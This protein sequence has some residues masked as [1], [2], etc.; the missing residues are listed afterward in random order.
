MAAVGFVKI[1][2]DIKNHWIYRD[3]DHFK[4]WFEMLSNA[5]YIEEPKTDTYQGIIY[6][7][8]YGEFIFSR[9]SWCKRLGIS[10]QKLRTLMT[11]MQREGM[12]KVTSRLTKLSIYK[13]VN[14]EKF[15]QQDNQ[16]ETHKSEGFQGIVNQQDN[17]RVTSRQ[18]SANQRIT[19]NKE[20]KEGE[21]GKEG[22]ENIVIDHFEEFWEQYPKKL[23]KT[24]ALKCWKTLI[25]NGVS[26]D[27]LI[28]ASK[29]YAAAMKGK[30][31]QFILQGSTFLGP[32]K[33][34]EDFIKIAPVSAASKGN[35]DKTRYDHCYE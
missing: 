27:D 5:R 31:Q 12:I 23:T 18:P 30:E 15:N 13:V 6:T 22:K 11:K 3:P 25:K 1:Y 9:I 17:Q 8:N 29:N 21:E 4:V 34:Y 20:S 35:K 19:T 16:Q 28:T 26:I 14:Y 33:R 10:E 7:L 24:S 2:R 32:Q